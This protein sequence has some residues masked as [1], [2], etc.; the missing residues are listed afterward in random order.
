[1][2]LRFNDQSRR[3]NLHGLTGRRVTIYGQQEAVKDMVA[4]RLGLAEQ[5]VGLPYES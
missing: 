2:A 3:I 4:A 1:M 5:Y